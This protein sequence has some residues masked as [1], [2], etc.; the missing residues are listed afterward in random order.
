MPVSCNVAL[1]AYILCGRGALG[2]ALR[3]RTAGAGERIS[4][5]SLQVAH[6]MR[7]E[8]TDS[9]EKDGYARTIFDANSVSA[10]FWR[11][12]VGHVASYAYR[13]RTPV[14]LARSPGPCRLGMCGLGMCRLGLCRLGMCGPGPCTRFQNRC[15][16]LIVSWAFV[17][18]VHTI[19]RQVHAPQCENPAAPPHGCSAAPPLPVAPTRRMGAW[20]CRCVPQSCSS[21]YLW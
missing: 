12:N 6:A 8:V 15:T 11:A 16:R 2:D 17:A 13:V 5:V 3:V 20:P 10:W 21:C 9:D 19:S 18:R 7:S 4:L 14:G 1:T